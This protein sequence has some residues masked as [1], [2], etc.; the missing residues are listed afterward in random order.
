MIKF[1][2]IICL[3]SSCTTKYYIVRHA[4]KKLND[5]TDPALTDEGFQ[6]AQDLNNYFGTKKPDE[7]FV[8][9]ALRTQQTAAPTAAAA[10]KVAVVVDQRGNN[11]SNGGNAN[12]NAFI[13][14]LKKID[15]K[16]VLV[17][18]HSDVIPE[19]IRELAGVT[20]RG[21][22]E[23]EYDNLYILTRNGKDWKFE[24]AIYGKVKLSTDV[25][26][27]EQPIK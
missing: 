14:Q 23:D 2:L 25:I 19:I 20:I 8:S 22:K 7:I 18:T 21:I 27:P 16:T 4:E 26:H 1:L 6:R 12:V 5:G 3:M 17:V 9:T 15:N 13:E 11:P 24:H 10:G